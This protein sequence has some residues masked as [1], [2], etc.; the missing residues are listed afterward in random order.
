MPPVCSNSVRRSLSSLTLK[1]SAMPGRYQTGSIA[2]LVTAISPPGAHDL[3]VD[4]DPFL[5]PVDANSGIV[6]RAL[7]IAMVGRMSRPSAI[8]FC[9]IGGD[10]VAPRIERD[11]AAR[12]GP[13]RERA[14]VDD[15]RGVGEIGPR[16]R[17]ERAGRHRK[18]AIERIGAAMRADRRCGRLGCDGADDRAAFA[19][20]RRAPADR[21]RSRPAVAG[22]RCQPDMAVSVRGHQIAPQKQKALS[23]EPGEWLQKATI[24]PVSILSRGTGERASCSVG[25]VPP[26]PARALLVCWA[27]L[28]GSPS[29]RAA[30]GRKTGGL[31][32]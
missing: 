8:S 5:V 4:L 20:A 26:D 31:V 18:R 21:V 16:H 9:K 29:R 32:K 2:A 13:L 25:R 11:D 1:R 22:M 6:S 7:V 15:R 28:T 23:G 19:R 17:I 14:D 3:A 24:M 10:A 27:T 30:T 12:L